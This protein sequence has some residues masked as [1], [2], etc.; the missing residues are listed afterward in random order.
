ML[1]PTDQSNWAGQVPLTQVAAANTTVRLSA[2]DMAGQT[3]GYQLA[4]F[5]PGTIANYNLAGT[6]P[7]SYITILGHNFDPNL[8]Q[9][10]FYLLFIAALLTSLVI[11]IAVKRHVQHLPLIANTAFVVIFA[12]LL[13]W[14]G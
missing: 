4:D 6:T 12:T 8:M 2:F 1:S 10:Q 7:V 11:A 3:A 13:W 5:S 14:G 9:N